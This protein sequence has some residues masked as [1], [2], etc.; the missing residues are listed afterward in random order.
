MNTYVTFVPRYQKRPFA[1][2]RLHG[3]SLIEILVVVTIMGI[4][5]AIAVPAYTGYITKARRALAKSSLLDLAQR[6]EKYYSLNNTYTVSAS[7][8]GYPAGTTFPMAIKGSDDTTTYYTIA[9]PTLTAATTTAP[10][11][12]SATAAPTGPQ[13]GDECGSFGIDSLGRQTASIKGCW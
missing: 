13:A 6:E 8:L 3:F 5:L 2:I 4:L 12:F 7:N 10:A 9:A 11:M 1:R